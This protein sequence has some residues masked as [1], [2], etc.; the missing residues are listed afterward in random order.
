[1]PHAA[2]PNEYTPELVAGLQLIWG[3]GFPSPGGEAAVEAIVSGMDLRDQ[4][5]SWIHVADKRAFFA[6]AFRVLRP[7]GALAASDWLR[8]GQPPATT[9]A[10]GSNSKV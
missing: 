8:S 7:G 5:D 4:K 1:M 2:H 9:C 3:E 10:T 6:E